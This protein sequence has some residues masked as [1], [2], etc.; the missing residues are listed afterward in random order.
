MQNTPTYDFSGQ[1]AFVTGAARG[2]GRSH[3]LRYAESGAD[4][5]VLD[6]AENKDGVV[7][8]LG[9]EDELY[10]VAD[11]IESMGQRALPIKADVAQADQV[12]AAVERAI[13]EFGHIDIL[14]NNAGIN[15]MSPMLELEEADWDDLMATDLK[16]VWLCSKH[17]GK[18]MVERGEGGKIINTSSSMGLIGAPGMGHYSA[19]KHGVIGLTKTLALELAEHDINVNAIAPTA[20]DSPLIQLN[21]ELFGPEVVEGM[22]EV[23]GPSNLFG[24]DGMVEVE[25]VTEAYMWL[26]SEASRY[27]TGT[28]LR[29]DGGLTAK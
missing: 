13:D 6:I 16:S 11:E 26:S 21:I 1:V 14:A 8:D 9:T 12:A 22:E 7:Y 4:V 20:V 27:V 17:V 19:A 3:A 28:V 25:D 15:T 23:A 10:S 24:N 5:V 2:Q 29:V 18:H